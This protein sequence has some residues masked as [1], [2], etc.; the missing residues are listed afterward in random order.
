MEATVVIV[1][2]GPAGLAASVCLSKFSISNLILEKEDCCASLWRKRVY[3]RLS[4]HLAKSFSELPYMPHLPTTPKFMPKREFVRYL[5]SY[6]SEFNLQPSY[7]RCVVSAAFR[8]SSKKWFIE[9][10]NLVSGENEHY[11]AKFLVVATGENGRPFFPAISGLDSFPG[12]IVHS[13]EYKCGSGYEDKEVL[14][15]GS[16]NS[17]MEISFD[18][19]NH[20]AYASVI[21]RSPVSCLVFLHFLSLSLLLHV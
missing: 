3:N 16:G 8:E 21:V 1:G 9:A 10:K 14:V 20:G 6:V 7:N 4:L 5:D 12:K 2:A 13:S 11:V 19:A 15:V 17:G 18:L